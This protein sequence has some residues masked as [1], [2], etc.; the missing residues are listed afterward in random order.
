MSALK[1][2]H[3]FQAHVQ[4]DVSVLVLSACRCVMLWTH[5]A[6]RPVAIAGCLSW[7]GCCY[8]TWCQSPRLSWWVS[9][10]NLSNLWQGKRWKC[11]LK[12][13]RMQNNHNC[14]F[15]KTQ[16]GLI[17]EIRYTSY[18]K[19]VRCKLHCSTCTALFV[20]QTCPHTL[21]HSSSKNL[22]SWDVGFSWQWLRIL[23]FP[24]IWCYVLQ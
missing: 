18:V 3:I 2:S 4:W 8:P 13:S 6:M 9:L 7:G 23:L 16:T 17:D 20:T 5:M 19:N 21:L 24:G 10:I 22:S 12:L 1:W 14:T 15:F 11:H